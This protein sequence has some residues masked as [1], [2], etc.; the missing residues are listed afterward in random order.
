MDQKSKIII[1]ILGILT[2]ISI[3]FAAKLNNEKQAVLK[4][5]QEEREAWGLK[6]GKLRENA[7]IIK[8]QKDNLQERVNAIQK[9]LDSA[10]REKG[11]FRSKYDIV[12]R[13]RDELVRRLKEKPK[14]PVSSRSAGMGSSEAPSSVSD[15]YWGSVLK[16]KAALEF[17]LGNI[18]DEYKKLRLH[19][20]ELTKEKTE[21]ELELTNLQHKNSDLQRRYDYNEKLLDSLSS[22]LVREKNDKQAITAQVN[23]IRKENGVLRRQLK[24]AVDA[25]LKLQEKIVNIEEEKE[26][27]KDKVEDVETVAMEKRT[28]LQASDEKLSRIKGAP[29]GSEAAKTDEKAVELSPIVV[30]APDAAGIQVSGKEMVGRIAAVD[31]EHNF[32]VIDIGEDA[33]VGIGMD[34]EVYQNGERVGTARVI[35]TRKSISA[36]DILQSTRE[37]KAGDIVR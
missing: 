37:I 14:A 24:L 25:K 10:E 8:K 3:L 27:L 7:E 22:E 17:D 16:D 6:E 32:V 31:M 5:Y 33:G 35:Q 1:V 11:E 34:F 36:A 20:E 15:Q 28:A 2:L 21:L 12:A 29:A 26:V 13:E 30:H 18:K 9:E 4:E 23:E 19:I